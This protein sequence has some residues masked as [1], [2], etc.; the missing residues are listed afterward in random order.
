MTPTARELLEKDPRLRIDVSRD[1]ITAYLHVNNTVKSGD[2]DLGDIRGSLTAHRITYGIKDTEKL[3][4]FL[5]NMDLYDHT[6]IVASG[7]PFTVGDDARIEFLFE[8]D[9][10]AALSDEL[11][12]SLDSIDF[13]SVGRIAS[14]KKGQVIAR[15]I[16]ATQGEEGITVYGQKLP[17]EWGMDITLQAGENVTVSQNGLDFM[18]A[19]DGAPIVSRGV[20]RVDPV[21]IIEGDV[22]HETGSI[23]FA[24]TVAVRGSIQ[25]G[26]TVQ[27]AGDIIVDNTVQAA[28]VEAGGDIVVRRGIL[29]RGKTRIHAEG[30]VFARFI[31]NSIV[32]AEGDIVV[33]T[34]IMNS[35]TRCNGRVVA[36]NGEGA[37]MGGQTLAFDCVLAKSIGSTANVKTYVQAGYRYD[38]QKQFLDAMAKLR[39]VQKQMAEVKKNYDFVSNTSGDFDKLGELRGQ[40]MKLLKIQKQ[41]Q[42]DI[43]EINNGRIFN[44]LASIDVENTL[45]PGATLLLGD[46]RFTVSKETGFASIKWDTEN[47]S[48]YMTTFD[49]SGRGKHSRPGKRARTA[50]VIDDSKSVRKTMALILEKMGLR[51]VAEAEDG[52]EGVAIFRETRPSLVTCDIAMVNMDGI[53][54]LRKIREIS[55]RAKVIMVS[56]NRDKKKVLDCVMAGAEDYI[57]KPFVPKKVMTVI[58]SVLEK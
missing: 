47:R 23:S 57:L 9:A 46:A 37:V 55:S 15:K 42:D 50:L 31:E 54:A 30:S 20:L 29:T 2:I 10:R 21:T 18:A 40:A 44:Q 13:R 56:S 28:T 25:D 32:E 1:H 19:I 5:E 27:A 34:A 6:L 22:G 24:G 11:T 35:D 43:T 58:R 38:V 36:L 53:E 4:V 33:E 17:G 7:K 3:S 52:A 48:L 8:A 49:E 12:A 16:P 51:V 14:V 45:Y 26:F 41:M 39:S